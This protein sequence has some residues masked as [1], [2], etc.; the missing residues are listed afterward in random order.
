MDSINYIT[1]RSFICNKKIINIF[2]FFVLLVLLA[3]LQGCS[4]DVPQYTNESIRAVPINQ[5]GSGSNSTVMSFAGVTRKMSQAELSFGVSGTVQTIL[6]DIGS[7]VSEGDILASLDLEPY[8][9]ALEGA[10][11]EVEKARASNEENKINYERAERLMLSNSVSQ[12]NLDAARTLYDN[13]QAT[14][15]AAQTRV[16]LAERDISQAVIRAPYDGVISSRQIEPFEQITQNDVVFKF[17]GSDGFIVESTVP[18][19]LAGEI[20]KG[21]SFDVTVK[22]RDVHFEATIEHLG[23]R[24]GNGLS[25]PIKIKVNDADETTL[26][27]GVVVEIN[28]SKQEDTSMLYVPHGAVV[29]ESSNDSAYIYLYNSVTETAN[30]SHVNILDVQSY[31]YWIENNFR[32]EDLYVA[33]GAAF[34]SEGQKV[35]PA[36]ENR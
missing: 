12:Q 23:A 31:G 1:D 6:V 11:S 32:E 30:K 4:E 22:W 3:C 8:Q 13:S 16:K 17:D 28:Y 2:L 27:T 25:F 33:A 35:R 24:A 10:Y 7:R 20:S 5:I 14:L 18:A 36:G 15:Q 29:V 34:I 9:L 26:P 21:E 19:N